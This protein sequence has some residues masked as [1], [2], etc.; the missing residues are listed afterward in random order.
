MGMSGDKSL[1]TTSAQVITRVLTEAEKL[2]HSDLIST[3]QRGS[4][5]RVREA[6]GSLAL[7][8]SFQSSL[9]ESDSSLL[10][11]NLIGQSGFLSLSFVGMTLF[12]IQI[13]VL[14]SR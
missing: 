6:A 12:R 13:Q 1:L 7:I 14:T 5:S 10:V 8:R 4:V 2:F 3:A 9:G 11:A